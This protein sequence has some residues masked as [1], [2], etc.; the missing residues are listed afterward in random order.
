MNFKK[1][2]DQGELR[3]IYKG[4]KVAL[5]KDTKLARDY[6]FVDTYREVEDAVSRGYF[7][8]AVLRAAIYAMNNTIRK[9]NPHLKNPELYS[10]ENDILKHGNR[11]KKQ[12]ICD[13]N[14][15]DLFSITETKI[16]IYGVF[17]ED[18]DLIVLQTDGY[19]VEKAGR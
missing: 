16:F 8:P 7:Q 13:V 3:Q 1:T 17:G 5:K 14:A 9:L 12:G 4:M 11:H 2:F 15:I 19:H 18:T 10:I 6:N